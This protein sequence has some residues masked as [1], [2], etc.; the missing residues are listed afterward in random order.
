MSISA[1]SCAKSGD[2]TWEQSEFPGVDT[3]SQEWTFD[4]PAKKFQTEQ[5]TQYIHWYKEQK[6]FYR[7][8]G[9]TADKHICWRNALLLGWIKGAV[10]AGLHKLL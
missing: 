10:T 8:I 1:N 9:F 4:K 7:A 3:H 2:S 6:L 5:R